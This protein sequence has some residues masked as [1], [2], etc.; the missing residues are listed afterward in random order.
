MVT[1]AAAQRKQLSDVIAIKGTRRKRGK[2]FVLPNK[3][4]ENPLAAIPF[5]TH[6]FQTWNTVTQPSSPQPV[7]TERYFC[8]F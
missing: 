6:S 5:S 1:V 8:H 2:K 4:W 7:N 3:R